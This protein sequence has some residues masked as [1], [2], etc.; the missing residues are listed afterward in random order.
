MYERELEV[1]VNAA[2]QAGEVVRGYFK[3]EYT[4]KDK[5]EDNPLTDA[6]LG[7]YF[8]RRFI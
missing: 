1:A 7:C 2:K 8:A 3:D 4:V 6:D 5:G